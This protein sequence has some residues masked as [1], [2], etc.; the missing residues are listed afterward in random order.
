MLKGMD[1]IYAVYQERSFSKAAE[2]LYISQPA[3]SNAIK[4]VEKELGLQ[5]FDR[6]SS[7][8]RPTP[9]GEY[10]IQGIQKI[11]AIEEEMEAHFAELRRA[12]QESLTIGAGT[13]FCAHLLPGL[14]LQ[15]E[16]ARPGCRIQMKEDNARNIHSDLLAGALDLSLDTE[17]WQDEAL[18]AIFLCRE[19]ILLAVPAG[20]EVNRQL[21]GSAL[22]FE[23]VRSGLYLEPETPAVS[24]E[25]FKDAPFLL[26]REGNDIH[27]RALQMCRNAGFEPKVE[28]ILDQLYTTYFV[29]C[30][31]RAATFVRPAITSAVPA[32]DQLLFYKLQDP[33]A[34][35]DIFLHYRVGAPQSP[36]RD[37]FVEFMK[38]KAPG[39]L[40]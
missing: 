16:S 4:K 7:P 31:G 18:A 3:L 21:Q 1:Q 8:V 24:L 17:D 11:R 12:K 28:M 20:W 5:L 40:R 6:S 9:A 38:Q 15:F 25:H 2:K 29:A 19:N 26:L 30:E 10:Y 14:A 27:R 39:P 22:T 32:T 35:R 13:F 23:Q 34:R 36:I 33:T 37:A